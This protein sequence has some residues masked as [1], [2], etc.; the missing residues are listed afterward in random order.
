[1]KSDLTSSGVRMEKNVLQALTAEVK[2]TIATGIKPGKADRS[3]FS[4]VDLWKIQKNR[5]PADSRL[6]KRT[7]N[8]F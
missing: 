6:R 8:I 1:M 3:T 7:V 2:E 4:A 5:R